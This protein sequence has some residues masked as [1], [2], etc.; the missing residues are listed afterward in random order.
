MFS[1]RIHVKVWFGLPSHC[2]GERGRVSAPRNSRG[3]NA[4]PLA[5]RRFHSEQRLTLKQLFD[6]NVLNNGLLRL[7]EDLFDDDPRKPPRAAAGRG[8]RNLCRKGI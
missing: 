4:T 6:T 3:A 7:S 2:A 5:R 1:S 8:G